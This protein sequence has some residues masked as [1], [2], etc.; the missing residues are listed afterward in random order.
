[1]LRICAGPHGRDFLFGV[2]EVG[3]TALAA[4]GPIEV[5][6]VG[7]DVAEMDLSGARVRELWAE[8]A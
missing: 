2:L 3:S 1:M 4:A 7:S 6:V 5:R 8:L